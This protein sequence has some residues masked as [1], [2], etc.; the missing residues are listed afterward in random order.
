MTREEEFKSKFFALL[1]EYNV[2]IEVMIGAGWD[3]G[4]RSIS[5]CSPDDIDFETNCWI[6]GDD[7]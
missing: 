4:P 1:R 2:T 3:A 5:F 7:E 6:S